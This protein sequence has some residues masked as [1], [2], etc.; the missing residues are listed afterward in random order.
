[1]FM[2][3]KKIFYYCEE[4]LNLPTFYPLENYKSIQEYIKS[5]ESQ[6]SVGPLNL[7]VELVERK[8]TLN[9]IDELF[10]KILP[11]FTEV[12]LEISPDEIEEDGF[13]YG[14]KNIGLIGIFGIQNGKK[15]IKDIS[16]YKGNLKSNREIIIAQKI[17]K[18]FFYLCKGEKLLIFDERRKK[19]IF[20]KSV[21]EIEDY[22]IS[23]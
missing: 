13:A 9:E 7:K 11:P 23:E 1:M 3:K 12:R 14:Y 4:M 5:Y 19:I 22:L 20:G 15:I 16:F 18:V 17:A 21:E 8:I 6:W 10:K 2:K